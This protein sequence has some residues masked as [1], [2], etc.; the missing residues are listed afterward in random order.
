MENFLRILRRKIKNHNKDIK[1]LINHTENF[2]DLCNYPYDEEKPK[3][4]LSKKEEAKLKKI[5][6]KIKNIK[7]TLKKKQTKKFNQNLEDF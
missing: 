5:I 2:L 6:E 7:S 3:L 4:H 1:T